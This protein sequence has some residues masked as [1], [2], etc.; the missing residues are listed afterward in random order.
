MSPDIEE[1]LSQNSLHHSSQEAGR[2]LQEDA[3]EGHAHSDIFLPD[4][5]Y[6]KL[7]KFPLLSPNLV[8]GW[9]LGFNT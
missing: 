6:W 5:L 7:T 8:V 1:I 2:K 9:D 4:Q 3:A